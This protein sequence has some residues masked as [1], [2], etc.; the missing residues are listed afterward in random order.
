MTL[1]K[2]RRAATALALVTSLSAAGALAA[3]EREVSR[4]GGY[5]TVVERRVEGELSPRVCARLP[6]SRH[7]SWPT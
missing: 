2:M 6:C 5:E 3:V 1:R 7:R 4:A